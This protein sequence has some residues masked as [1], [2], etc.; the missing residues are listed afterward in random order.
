MYIKYIY[1]HIPF[2]FY[3]SLILFQPLVNIHWE[4]HTAMVLPLIRPRRL[5]YVYTITPQ[6]TSKTLITGPKVF[7]FPCTRFFCSLLSDN[8]LSRLY[9][10]DYNVS[11]LIKHFII[12]TSRPYTS[13]ILY[14]YLYPR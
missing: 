3:P 14:I 13:S 2:F 8:K 6:N 10:F 5:Q 11:K 4:K 7:F 12:D 1:I 9:G